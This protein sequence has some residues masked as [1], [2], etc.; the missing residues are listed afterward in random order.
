VFVERLRHE[1]PIERIAMVKRQ[2][3]DTGGVA[4]VDRQLV[5][6][7]DGEMMRDALLLNQAC[8]AYPAQTVRRFLRAAYCP[9]R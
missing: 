1:Q 7:I 4:N 5:E 3:G 8:A 2:S 6:A 9:W